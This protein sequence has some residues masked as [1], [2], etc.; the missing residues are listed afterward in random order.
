MNKLQ[1]LTNGANVGCSNLASSEL[2]DTNI[3]IGINGGGKSTLL[4]S[5][6]KQILASHDDELSDPNICMIDAEGLY[7]EDGLISGAWQTIINHCPERLERVLKLIEDTYPMVKSISVS[8]KDG[9]LY[10][11]VEDSQV[12]AAKMGAGFMMLTSLVAAMF[13][14]KNGYVIIDDFGTGLHLDAT[15]HVCDFIVEDSM[16]N[17][18]QIFVATHCPSALTALKHATDEQSAK[19]A[20]FSAES[21]YLLPDAIVDV[22]VLKF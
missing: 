6:R 1:A 11:E 9:M 8:N 10:A 16:K 12:Q 3:F 22:K 5:I 7:D 14:S 18:I 17:N 2:G 19:R 13:V 21:A 4:A 20:V 15:D